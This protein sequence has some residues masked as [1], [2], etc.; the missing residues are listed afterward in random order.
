MN[1]IKIYTLKVY[2]VLTYTRKTC[3]I[4]IV[5]EEVDEM[6]WSKRVKNQKIERSKCGR[7][8]KKGHPIIRANW[9]ASG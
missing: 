7:E 8:N 9:T 6:I 5:K 3:I 4:K 1:K 2:K